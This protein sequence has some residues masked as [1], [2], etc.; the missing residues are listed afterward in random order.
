MSDLARLQSKPGSHPSD[1]T[2]PRSGGKAVSIP[3]AGGATYPEGV[4]AMDHIRHDM[5]MKRFP[6]QSSVETFL[7]ERAAAQ[8]EVTGDEFARDFDQAMQSSEAVARDEEIA[9]RCALRL[10][11]LERLK[12]EF[13][14]EMRWVYATEDEKALVL[15]NLNGFV[16]FVS[17]AWNGDLTR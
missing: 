7:A 5:K 10:A 8:R 12:A 9:R 1:Q 17:R 4:T 14:K 11:D 15:S 2:A 3:R 16:S 13:I 6:E